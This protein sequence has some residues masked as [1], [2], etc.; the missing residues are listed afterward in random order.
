MIDTGIMRWGPRAG[1]LLFETGACCNEFAAT[2]ED[3]L[4]FPAAAM[5]TEFVMSHIYGINESR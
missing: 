3:R 2:K 5:R 4:S 1:G